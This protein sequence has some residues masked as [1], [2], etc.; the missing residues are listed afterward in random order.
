METHRS[1]NPCDYRVYSV[2]EGKII[3]DSEYNE[4]LHIFSLTK[5]I[6]SLAIGSLLITHKLRLDDDITDILGKEYERFRGVTVRQILN[7]TSGIEPSNS[8]D[9][10]I[11]ADYYLSKRDGIKNYILTLERLDPPGARYSYNNNTPDLLGAIITKITGKDP[12]E[13]IREV[14]FT[15]LG[16]THPIKDT[17]DIHNI[18]FCAFGLYLNKDDLLTLALGVLNDRIVPEYT[19]M[20]KRDPE[21]YMFYQS[22]VPDGIYMWGAYGQ[23]VYISPR[24][25]CIRQCSLSLLDLAFGDARLDWWQGL[26]D[27]SSEE[28][29]LKSFCK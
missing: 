19:R 20:I 5:S 16:I 23:I 9:P 1:M 15:P 17:R 11:G 7:H 28:E 22:G 18:P 12:M 24:W 3:Y 26:M 21:S 25:I 8:Y 2:T 29:I 13:Y 4:Y 27:S 14:I 6:V 10:Y